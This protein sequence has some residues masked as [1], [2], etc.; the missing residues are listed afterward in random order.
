MEP[1]KAGEAST[2]LASSRSRR[3]NAGSKMSQMIQAEEDEFYTSTYGGFTEEED[4]NDFKESD[5]NNNVEEDYEVDSDFSI[6]ETDEIV[7]IEEDDGKKKK[8]RGT[9][10]TRAYKEPKKTSK[11]K[12]KI[13]KPSTASTREISTPSKRESSVTIVTPTKGSTS[14]FNR[15]F[16]ESTKKKTEQTMIRVQQ[17]KRSRRK[18][19]KTA[20]Y[21]PLTQ[22]ELLKEAKKTEQENLKSLEFYQKLESERIKRTKLIKRVIK[23]PFIRYQSLSMPILENNSD[24]TN[25][26]DSQAPARYTRNFITFSDELIFPNFQKSS[27]N[28]G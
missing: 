6:D 16:R 8:T 25:N 7:E 23:G 24:Q 13:D 21:K 1:E 22:E 27:K 3:V 14:T 10:S 20:N 17:A 15:T 18:T 26:V 11:P 12:Q 19:R 2:S 5:D 4:D 9:L 28:S